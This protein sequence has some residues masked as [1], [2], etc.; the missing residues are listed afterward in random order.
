MLL[1]TTPQ[2]RVPSRVGMLGLV[3]RI[4][5]RIVLILYNQARG[6]MCG[7]R[8]AGI[9]S[10]QL[11]RQLC[12]MSGTGKL[13]KWHQASIHLKMPKVKLSS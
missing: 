13:L 6:A 10:P 8:H 1:D 5:H 4:T 9:C 2:L 3:Q 11:R 7:V 12:C